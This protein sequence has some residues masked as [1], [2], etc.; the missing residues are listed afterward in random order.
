M[1]LHNLRAMIVAPQ[2]ESLKRE[3]EVG[4]EEGLRGGRARGKKTR[5]VPSRS[6]GQNLLEWS[7]VNLADHGR[8][9]LE[10]PLYD[11]CQQLSSLDLA[12]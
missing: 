12:G 11:G 6:E 10:L 2:R 5:R 3:V 9:F 7:T 8:S 1:M 4:C